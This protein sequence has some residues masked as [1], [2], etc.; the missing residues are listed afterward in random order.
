[1][2]HSAGK[3][4]WFRARAS[5]GGGFIQN[6]SP[7]PCDQDDECDTDGQERQAL[8]RPF[9]CAGLFKRGRPGALD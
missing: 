8:E 4:C 2:Q 9:G 7:S 5:G 6:P 3:A 1:M